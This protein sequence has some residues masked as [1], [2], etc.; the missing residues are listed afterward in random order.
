MQFGFS[1]SNVMLSSIALV[2]LVIL[3][4]SSANSF[5]VSAIIFLA[6]IEKSSCFVATLRVA[7][8]PVSL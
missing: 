2:L 4:V 3:S 7:G 1:S 5:L 8:L 6:F